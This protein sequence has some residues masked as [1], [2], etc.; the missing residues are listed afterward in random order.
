MEHYVEDYIELESEPAGDNLLASISTLADEAKDLEAKIEDLEEQVR[1]T[2]RHYRFIIEERLPELM[3]TAKQT[4]LKSLSGLQLTLCEVVRA[5]I[6]KTK[7]TEAIAWL[8]EHGF[9]SII[10]NQVSVEIGKGQD[11]LAQRIVDKLRLSALKPEF[12][13]VVH[14]QTL[15]KTIREMLEENVDFSFDLF[16]V[17]IQKQV[18]I[19]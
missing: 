2:K 6:P 3:Q 18:K 9:A 15:Q 13:S 17:H 8:R 19:K 14:P 12:R 10:K 5:S 16:G 4:E 7:E 1:I 11:E